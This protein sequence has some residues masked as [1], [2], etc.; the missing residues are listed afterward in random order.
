MVAAGTLGGLPFGFAAQVSFGG[1]LCS[2]DAGQK[3][4]GAYLSGGAFAGDTSAINAV[5]SAK[6]N[7]ARGLFAGM[8]P[9]LSVSPQAQRP[10]DLSG[11]FRVV[12]LSLGAGLGSGGFE[13]AEGTTDDGRHIDVYTANLPVPVISPGLGA[14]VVQ[15]ETGTLTGQLWSETTGWTPF[16]PII[17]P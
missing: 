9:Q 1:V 7:Q 5:T 8:S 2:T 17:A 4:A 16:N 15:Q 11:P 14:A 6:G 12:S 10:A 3:S 13:L